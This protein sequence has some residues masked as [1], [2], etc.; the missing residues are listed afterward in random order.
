MMTLTDKLCH[1]EDPINNCSLGGLCGGCFFSG[2]SLSC[3]TEEKNKRVYNLL[4]QAVSGY[5]QSFEYQ[6]IFESPLIFGYRNK[7]EYSFGDCM[8]DGPLTLGLHKK[9]S[10]YDVIDTDSCLLVHDDYNH[11]VRAAAEY[12]RAAG[13]TYNDKKSHKG[14]LRYLIIR[15]AVNTGEMLVDLV[16]TSQ[17]PVSVKKHRDIYASDLYLDDGSLNP[18]CEAEPVDEEGL[19]D[20]FRDV[21]LKLNSGVLEGTIRGILHTINDARADAVRNDGTGILY[22]DDYITEELLGLK[23]D[24]SPFSFFQTNTRGA[25]LLYS[26][27]REFISEKLDRDMTLYDLYSG[28]G[29]IAQMLA[30]CVK[31]VI[32]VEIIEEAVETAKINAERN[33]LDN[34]RFIAD[35]VLKAIETLPAPDI[36]VLD[37]PRDGVNPKALKRLIDYGVKHILYVSC[38]PESLARDLILLEVAG[39]RLIKA[40]AIDQFTWTN[41]VETVVLISRTDVD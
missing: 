24:I 17:T 22:G 25:E 3:Q 18:A 10:F 2:K 38:K 31:T 40:A 41:N 5:S 26:K 9:K 32:G 16:T 29:T 20:G 21:L 33:G 4:T 19:L 15:R 13:V 27:I 34:C 36:M 12:F 35:D 30:P 7:M 14:Y 23:F 28:T 1:G 8:K 11:I 37:P 39:Y 6:G